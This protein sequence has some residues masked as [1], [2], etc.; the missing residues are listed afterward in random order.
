MTTIGN[1]YDYIDSFAPFVSQMGFDNAGLLIGSRD[2]T[3][4]KVMLSLDATLQ[5]AEQAAAQNCELL[6]THHP[7]IFHPASSIPGGSAVYRLIAAG[8]DVISAHTNFDIA[9][10]GVNTCLARKLGFEGFSRP[11]WLECGVVGTLPTPMTAAELGKFTAERIGCSG[12]RVADGGRPITTVAL[13]GGSGGSDARC[14]YGRADALITG[15]ASHHELIDA[16]DNGFTVIVAGHFE[17]EALALEPLGE[18][19][20]QQFPDVEFIRAQEDNPV[21]IV[22]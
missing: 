12:V 4:S 13:I 17:T 18:L 22:G 14:L 15:E 10:G 5:V 9:D 16:K 2:R 11:E 20:R 3:V 7:I 21:F 1:I 6:V 19:L 8:V